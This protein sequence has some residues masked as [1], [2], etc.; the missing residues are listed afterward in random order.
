LKE[1]EAPGSVTF[2]SDD[3]GTAREVLIGGIGLQ[4]ELMGDEPWATK[5]R[6]PSN[7]PIGEQKPVVLGRLRCDEAATIGTPAAAEG[8]GNPVGWHGR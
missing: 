5:L 6:K 7:V 4:A 1:L 2:S 8:A 3:A